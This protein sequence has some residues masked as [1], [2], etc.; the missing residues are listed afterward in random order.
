[1]KDFLTN[2]D[3]TSA[4]VRS[5]FDGR[6]LRV[7][8]AKGSDFWQGT[9]YGFH[10]DSGHALLVPV[11]EVGSLE[12]TFQASFSALYDQ[13]G[14]MIRNSEKDWLKA[15]IEINDGVQ[16]AAAV[17]TREQ[18]DWSLSAVPEW[19]GQEVTIRASW[20][21]GA[22]TI[23]ARSN[24]GAWNTLRLAPMNVGTSTKA[25]LYVCSPERGGLGVTFSAVKFGPPDAELH[26]AP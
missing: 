15:G 9:H 18:S 23:R 22:V 17:V 20:R 14:L 8:A 12:V 5:D 16:H 24:G 13:A 11:G 21:N 6:F 1:M 4:P 7:E 10:R 3:W 26:S 25:G 2:A 19:A